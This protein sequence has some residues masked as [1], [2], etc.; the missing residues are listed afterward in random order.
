M[1]KGQKLKYTGTGFIGFH[2]AYTE[3][4]FIEMDGRNDL[5]VYD[6]TLNTWSELS[7]TGGPPVARS[8]HSA[9]TANGKMFV[10]GGTIINFGTYVNDLWKYDFATNTW[11][12]CT[13]ASGSPAKRAFHSI[14]AINGIIYIFGG[15]DEESV[16][17]RDLWEYTP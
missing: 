11:V 6:L 14:A 12:D 13:P 3:M 17:L 16:D 8:Y 4:T 15:E 2:P 1:K 7:P 10:F 5:W 9:V